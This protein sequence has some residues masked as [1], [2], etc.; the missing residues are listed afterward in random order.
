MENVKRYTFGGFTFGD[1]GMFN[2]LVHTIGANGSGTVV[3]I[4]LE[5]TPAERQE[6]ITVL[7]TL[8]K[9]EPVE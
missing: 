9:V 3:E 2:L 4:A 5:L 6:L 7:I 1:K 8:A